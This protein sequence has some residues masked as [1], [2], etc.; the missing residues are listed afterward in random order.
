MSSFLEK[1]QS[2]LAGKSF[3]SLFFIEVFCG[4]GRLTATIRKLGL[5]GAFGVDHVM[6][7][8]LRSP[9]IKLDLT[10]PQGVQL[11]HECLMHEHLAW[12]HFAPPCGTSSQARNIKK[13]GRYNPPPLRSHREPD[14]M[15]NMPFQ[16]RGRVK[17]ANRLYAVTSEAVAICHAR[18]IFWSVENPYR[19]FM[20]LT[21]HWNSQSSQLPY[22]NLI[23][24]HC[25]FGGQTQ[26][27][28]DI[29]HHPLFSNTRVTMR[30]EH[31]PWVYPRQ[32]GLLLKR[33]LTPWDLVM[34][35]VM[36][37]SNRSCQW[38]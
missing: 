20:W 15:K 3:T 27:N 11:F 29:A 35:F 1:A 32:D 24:D 5:H 33:L 2:R 19:S 13:P 4:T 22:L 36:H 6:H 30:R 9:A 21:S 17:S 10:T 37:F 16:F 18:G 31:L 26:K 7:Q 34:H 12:V 38:A 23:F 8:K 28:K 25:M 14:G